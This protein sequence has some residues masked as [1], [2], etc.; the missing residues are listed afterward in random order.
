MKPPSKEQTR[1]AALIAIEDSP[2]QVYIC[3]RCRR[4][5]QPGEDRAD[6]LMTYEE[7]G[8][9]FHHPCKRSLVLYN[10]G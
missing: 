6:F 5:L 4:V 1:R 9:I 8:T 3:P 7:N 2:R 10:R